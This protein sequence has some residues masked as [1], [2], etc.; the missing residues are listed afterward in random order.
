[1]YMKNISRATDLENKVVVT[2][3]EREGGA[4]N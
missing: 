4:A 1:M 2:Q 3:G